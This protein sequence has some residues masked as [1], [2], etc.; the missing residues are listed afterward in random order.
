[1]DYIYMAKSFLSLLFFAPGLFLLS[2]C[3]IIGVLLFIEKRMDKKVGR[4]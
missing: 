3:V 2:F 4:D 1:M